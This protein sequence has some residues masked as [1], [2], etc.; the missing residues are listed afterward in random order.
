MKR[1]GDSVIIVPI[2]GLC[3]RLRVVAS[4][5]ALAADL[6]EKEV[7]GKAPLPLTLVWR[8]TDDCRAWFDELFLKLPIEGVRLIRGNFRNAPATKHNLLLPY[9]W[10]KA[11]GFSEYRCYKPSDDSSFESLLARH[12]RCYVDT[13]YAL[14]PYPSEQ[15]SRWVVPLPTLQ[16]RIN[17]LTASFTAHTLGVHIRRTDN[18]QAILHSPLAAFSSAIDTHMDAGRASTLF[19]CTDDEGVKRQMVARYGHRV[20]TNPHPARRDTLAGMEEAVVELW[21]LAHTSHILGSYYSSFSD[22][23]SE[24]FGTPLEIVTA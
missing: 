13:C 6:K 11:L 9:L 1:R 23:A 24:L 10:R 18:K 4:A 5:C 22:T 17:T 19:L 16:A 7:A 20:L 15:L 14:H 12:A 8:A 3:N 2:S 21:A